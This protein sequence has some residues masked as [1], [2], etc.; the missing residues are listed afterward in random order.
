MIPYGDSTVD[1]LEKMPVGE[2]INI[3]VLGETGVGKSTF[4]N[5]F[6]NYLSF[7]TLEEAEHKEMIA[8]IPTN[9]WFQESRPLKVQKLTYSILVVA[10]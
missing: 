2:E 6:A 5:A 1:K 8:L 7:E 3:L 4:I 10:K 9:V